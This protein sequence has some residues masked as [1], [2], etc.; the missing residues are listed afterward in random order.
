[1][2]DFKYLAFLH[3][4][5][6]GQFRILPRGTL[7]TPINYTFLHVFH[8][9][10]S[11]SQPANLVPFCWCRRLFRDTELRKMSGRYFICTTVANRREKKQRKVIQPSP[12][13]FSS[14][15]EA[16]GDPGHRN[17]E[18]LT[19]DSDFGRARICVALPALISPLFAALR[20]ADRRV[21]YLKQARS[22][23]R[24]YNRVEAYSCYT[25][26]GCELVLIMKVDAY[27][28]CGRYCIVC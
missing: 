27:H 26:L 14:T 7:N 17:H 9:R 20:S 3:I 15:P 22:Y 28:V 18:N 8:S 13:A 2:S 6:P 21:C 4:S 5:R 10:S 12:S 1:L 25:A 19:S 23:A 16:L 24:R 11:Y